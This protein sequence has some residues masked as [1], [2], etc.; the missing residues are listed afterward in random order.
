MRINLQ[1]Q[2]CRSGRAFPF[3]YH[4]GSVMAAKPKL[5]QN[6]LS[7]PQA[8]ERIAAALGDLSGRTVVEI[9]P[10]AGAITSALAARA[11]H[12]LAVEL[13]GGLAA[14]LCTRFPPSRITV[15][16]QDVLK[17]D[18]AAALAQFTPTSV[19]GQRLLVFGNLPYGITSQ[20]LLKLAASHASL[21]RAVLMVQREV[22][23]RITAQ[24]GS[25]DYGLL[26]VSVQM[27]G[28]AESLFTLPPQSFSPPPDVY[29]TVFR[30][31]FAPRFTELG[32]DEVGFLPF[33]RKAFAHK[34]K[35]LLNNLRAAGISP[36]AAVWALA[37]A[38][39][40]PFA[41]SE[42]LSIEALAALFRDLQKVLPEIERAASPSEAALH[43]ESSSG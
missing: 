1:I 25:R 9:G 4:Q 28:P 6:F 27:Y 15:V 16:Q 22:A 5:G 8:A 14:Y 41:R 11:A 37:R 43:P 31:R 36:S 19:A 32:L 24:P 38:G 7:D 23:D 42:A 40:D 13:D 33:V 34:R 35:T 3:N 30:W 17:F 21:D 20:I 10:G 12:V 26:S 29:S 2:V 18:F 39:I